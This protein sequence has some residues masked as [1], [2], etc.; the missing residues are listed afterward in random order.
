MYREQLAVEPAD[1]GARAG[2]VLSLYDLGQTAEADKE[3]AAALK[4]DPRNLALL[5][6]AAYWFVAHNDSKRGL[7]LAQ[8]A[9]DIEPRYTWTQIALARALI[10]EKQPS[11]CRTLPA[12]CPTVWEYFRP[13]TTN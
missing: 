11:V 1:K 13:S 2:L 5:T 3:F 10:G 12:L 8:R 6:G 4:D 7:E 9:A